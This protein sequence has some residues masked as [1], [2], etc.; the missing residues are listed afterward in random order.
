MVRRLERQTELVEDQVRAV[1]LEAKASQVAA[2]VSV[3]TP[4]R[5]PSPFPERMPVPQLAVDLHRVKA[6]PG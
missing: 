6:P 5:A 1:Q 2:A 4:T 3:S